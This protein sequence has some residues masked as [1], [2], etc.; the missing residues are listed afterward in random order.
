MQKDFICTCNKCNAEFKPQFNVKTVDEE[1]GVKITYLEC[2]EC[3]KRYFAG[4]TDNH[5]E[6]MLNKYKRRKKIFAKAFKENATDAVLK[7]LSNKNNNFE[8]MVL[9]PYYE[10]LKE[11]WSNCFGE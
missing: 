7:S 2:P 11:E 6:K 9:K 10:N 3:G 4:V 1:E 8:Q 5:Y